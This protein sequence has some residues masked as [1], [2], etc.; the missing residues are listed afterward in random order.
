MTVNVSFIHILGYCILIEMHF[1]L[2]ITVFLVVFFLFNITNIY[3]S[4]AKILQEYCFYLV[5]IGEI[6]LS[7]EYNFSF[8]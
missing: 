1:F 7:N 8:Q 3:Q 4:N 6:L 2:Y 5:D